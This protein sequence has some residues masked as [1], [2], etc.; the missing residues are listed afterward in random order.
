M[1]D[2]LGSAAEGAYEETVRI[3]SGVMRLVRASYD[4]RERVLDWC[5]A[6]AVVA[7]LCWAFRDQIMACV[8]VSSDTNAGRH[9]PL[10]P[11]E[12]VD[13]ALPLSGVVAP[14]MPTRDLYSWN[15]PPS[16]TIAFQR[17][18]SATRRPWNPGMG[19]QFPSLDAGF[20]GAC[21]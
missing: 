14:S 16:R 2:D 11:S 18:P 15:M 19:G 3:P 9:D 8:M 7:A 17:G 13:G 6:F 10:V 1:A 4:S 5:L 21:S 12:D 20:K